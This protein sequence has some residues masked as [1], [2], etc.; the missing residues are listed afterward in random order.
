MPEKESLNWY[1]SGDINN[2]QSITLHDLSRLDSLLGGSFSD[3][4]DRLLRDRA[5]MDGDQHLSANDRKMLAD[6]LDG[7]KDYL[8]AH[9]DKLTTKEERISWLEKVIAIDRT[10]DGIADPSYIGDYYSD[11]LLI[12]TH[13]FELEVLQM[14]PEATFDYRNNGRFNLPFSYAGVAYNRPDLTMNRNLLAIIIGDNVFDW[15]DWC[16]VDPQWD[17]LI[18]PSGQDEPTGD[19]AFPPLNNW[20]DDINNIT[21]RDSIAPLVELS[22]NG[23]SISLTNGFF[24]L[25]YTISDPN[26][27]KASYCIESPKETEII[28]R[29]SLIM[30]ASNNGLIPGYNTS[31]T[32]DLLLKNGVYQFSFEAVDHFQNKTTLEFQVEINDPPPL[33]SIFSPAKDSTYTQELP[34]FHFEIE[35]TDYA[36]GWYSLDSGQTLIN[37]QQDGN[38]LL[39]LEDGEHQLIVFAKDV[40]ENKS[41]D[42]ISFAVNKQTPV[43]NFGDQEQTKLM[44]Y[45]NPT[46]NNLSILLHYPDSGYVQL[47]LMDV[48]RRILWTNSLEQLPSPTLKFEVDMS[49]YAAGIYF[50]R[51]IHGDSFTVEKIIKY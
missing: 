49:G 17:Q 26:L 29:D 24:E 10:E 27:W 23:N 34:A 35:E 47:D 50:L 1:G 16:F 32:I 5:D 30:N 14:F 48:N 25:D 28:F 21:R 19:E 38:F 15:N 44:V 8:P 51:C 18:F 33:I 45:P 43:A 42:T 37:I 20:T 39:D 36:S 11:Q 13:G 9:W 40:F 41:R 2:D 4:G 22:E 12:N 46:V 6:Y 7:K 31:G 3:Q